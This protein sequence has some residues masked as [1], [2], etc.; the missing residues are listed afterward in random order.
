VWLCAAAREGFRRG[1][2][3]I[4]L[5]CTY[6]QSPASRADAVP[7]DRDARLLWR[8]P[9]RRLGAEEIR[10]TL[11]SVAGQL[12]LSAYGLRAFCRALINSNELLFLD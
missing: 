6:R 3:Q 7:E 12:R 1:H 8:F 9:P 11:L 2:R 4:L 10:D 5:S